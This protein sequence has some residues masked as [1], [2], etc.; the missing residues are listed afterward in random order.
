MSDF[1]QLR[2]LL[3][4]RL[5]C[6]VLSPRDFSKSCPLSWSILSVS[7]STAPFSFCFQ[8]FQAL[9]SFPVSQHFASDGQIIG[10]STSATV[11]PVNIQSW[12]LRIDWFYLSV[13]RT[14]KS[15]LQHQNSKASILWCSAFFMD[16]IYDF[17]KNHSFDNTEFCWYS[18]SAQFSHSVMSNSLRPHEPQHARPPCPSPTP[19]VHPDSR[20]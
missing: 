10:G 4:T 2:R 5:L 8:F 15:L 14:L 19:R 9:S 18:L 1:L 17:W 12:F 3:Y 7:F 6:P 20:P 13:Q 11:L 16:Q